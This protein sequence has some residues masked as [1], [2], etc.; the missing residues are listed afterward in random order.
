MKSLF[1]AC[2]G[3]ILAAALATPAAA[4]EAGIYAGTSADG[5]GIQFTVSTD[6]NTGDLALTSAGIGFSAP[7]KNS[8][9]VLNT[10]WGF[11]LTADIVN[12]KVTYEAIDNYFVF[13]FSLTFSSD[14][15]TATGTITSYSPTVTPLTDKPKKAL[16]CVSPKQT[17]SLTLQ[18]PTARVSPALK[19]PVQFDPLSRQ[20]SQ[21]LR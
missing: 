2:G 9:D 3:I 10:G 12:S 1:K 14:G 13:D 6:P 7:C 4:Q 16:F 5:V 11:G 8:T 17:M 21:I 20:V 15:Q 18:P 19:G